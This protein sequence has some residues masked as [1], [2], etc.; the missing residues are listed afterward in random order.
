MRDHHLLV[1]VIVSIGALGCGSASSTVDAS[2]AE[3]DAGRDGDA[4]GRPDAIVI[5]S[6]SGPPGAE[7]ARRVPYPA[8]SFGWDPLEY[9]TSGVAAVTEC[10]TSVTFA[11]TALAPHVVRGGGMLCDETILVSGEHGVLEGFR[12]GN[13]ESSVRV[14][15][16]SFIVVRDIEHGGDNT[17]TSN[18]SSMNVVRSHHIVYFRNHIHNLMDTSG[19]EEVDYHGF[20]ARND[21]D[22]IWY[23]DNDVHEL[24]G[25]S[26]RTGTNVASLEPGQA[27]TT[28]VYI[29]RNRFWG[30]GENPI[31]LKR[32]RGI[33]MSS[34]DLY[35]V[36]ESVSSA[37]EAIVTHEDAQ[38]IEVY[39]NR[40]R[41]HDR[42][43]RS[44]LPACE[45]L[46]PSIPRSG[47]RRD[48]GRRPKPVRDAIG[49]DVLRQRFARQDPHH[50]I[51][52][53]VLPSVVH[54]AVAEE[55]L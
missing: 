22:Q 6:D 24:G 15:D 38:E 23:L 33:V 25:D 9:D 36:G 41:Q 32:S 53:D 39:D 18:G 19:T 45:P 52:E 54:L 31:D 14:S 17:G 21:D 27:V 5:R 8:E 1:A 28:N 55:A 11:G 40:V 13:I 43:K 49:L 10:P 37:G 20:V 4:G 47:R 30:N 29:A 7:Y 34:N 46:P 48:H 3:V 51:G 42:V 44:A 16:A 35:G 2:I 26:M 50:P 12:F